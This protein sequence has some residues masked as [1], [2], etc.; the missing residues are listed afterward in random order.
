MTFITYSNSIISRNSC[1]A[2]IEQSLIFAGEEA[3]K[4]VSLKNILKSRIHPPALIFVQSKDRAKQ[5][6][7]EMQYYGIQ[8]PFGMIHS[9]QPFHQVKNYFQ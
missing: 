3:T 6:F 2:D 5:L 9:D 8:I 1:C 7:H 4:L